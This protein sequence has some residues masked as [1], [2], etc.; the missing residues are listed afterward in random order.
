[1]LLGCLG[2]CS[3]RSCRL[4]L[5][6]LVLLCLS[7]LLLLLLLL[8]LR[9]LGL[10]F[11]FLFRQLSVA[12]FSFP[13]ELGVGRWFELQIR[14]TAGVVV[15]SIASSDK[16]RRLRP[17]ALGVIRFRLRTGPSVHVVHRRRRFRVRI[18][19]Q[20]FDVNRLV[21]VL[22]VR[23]SAVVT[24]R[25]PMSRMVTGMTRGRSQAYITGRCM[26]VRSQ[27]IHVARFTTDLQLVLDEGVVWSG[28]VGRRMMR[29]TL[30]G[31]PTKWSATGRTCTT[32]RRSTAGTT[33]ALATA[34]VVV[35]GSSGCGAR[36]FGT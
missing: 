5:M 8:L 33:T 9:L 24:G 34:T 18:D 13:G 7:G 17:M 2:C 20:R 35:V 25:W 12:I 16:Y 36:W 15:A 29:C 26:R 1:M 19:V 22:V 23:R 31:T 30:E 27:R 10:P 11:P 21:G 4:L 32:G 3:R 28:R 6:L 14:S